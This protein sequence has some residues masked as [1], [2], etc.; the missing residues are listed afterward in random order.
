MP[1]DISSTPRKYVVAIAGNMGVGKTTMTQVV[2]ERFGW[3]PFCESVSDNPYLADFYE[4]MNRWSFNLQVYFLSHRFK[5]HERIAETGFSCVQDRSI[6]E[7]V[8]VFAR[9]LHESGRMSDRDYANYRALFEAMTSY[10][11]KPDLFVYLRAS[12]DALISRI[13]VRDRAF[14]RSVSPEYLHQ[15][16]IFYERWVKRLR[17]T[18][19]VLVVE[20]D[21]FNFLQDT[22]QLGPVLEQIRLYCPP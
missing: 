3:L 16:N 20:T 6:Y 18:E 1:E 9:N 22:D 17:E 4:D 8:E 21:T 7:D 19:R 10:L 11:R 12:T 2:S 14:E 15:L 5:T 13:R